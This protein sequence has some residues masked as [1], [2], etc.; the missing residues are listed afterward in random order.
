MKHLGSLCVLVG[1]SGLAVLSGGCASN[2]APAVTASNTPTCAAPGAYLATNDTVAR[3][4]AAQ[5]PQTP[6]V[7]LDPLAMQGRGVVASDTAGSDLA[8]TMART[9]FSRGGSV[10]CE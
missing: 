6:V 9:E 3:S 1:L 4:S 10:T 8:R 2:A 7:N 5:G